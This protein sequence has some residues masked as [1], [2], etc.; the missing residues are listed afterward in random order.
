MSKYSD[1]SRRLVV[2]GLA[3]TVTGPFG[4]RTHPIKKTPDFHT[5]TDYN[6]PSGTPLASPWDGVVT[7]VS[8]N[9][10]EEGYGG[11]VFIYNE[12]VDRT[13]YASH[14]KDFDVVVGQQVKKGQRIGLSGG[15]KKP[16]RDKY[17]GSSTG[18][19][20]HAGIILGK[21][22]SVPPKK[23]NAHL[24]T[25]IETYDFTRADLIVNEADVD[26]LA[27]EV[28]QGK[29]GNGL[30]RKYHLEA[31]GHDYSII[32]S[33]V[34]EMLKKPEQPKPSLK[35]TDVVAKEV[36]AGKWGNGSARKTQLTNAG[37]N[38]T[39]IQKRVDEMLSKPK[40]KSNEEIAKEVLLGRW[41][42]GK[43]R[44]DALTKAGYNFDAIQAIVNKRAK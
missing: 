35:P 28:I 2:S 11:T 27:K 41:G 9:D 5:G 6:T 7:G 12:R 1:V 13:Y 14:M 26:R 37:Y 43:A 15:A 18:S 39:A 16:R 20:L 19:H 44:K 38:Y 36:I 10:S 21:R 42:N 32:Q 31:Q 34:D 29:W 22:S 3:Y 40:L 8:K 30:D 17:A 24:F 4:P 23:A 25:D 33:R